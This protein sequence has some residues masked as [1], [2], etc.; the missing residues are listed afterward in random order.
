MFNKT[1]RGCIVISRKPHL[2]TCISIIQNKSVNTIFTHSTQK[3]HFKYCA[4]ITRTY[5]VLNKSMEVNRQYRENDE[6]K[7]QEFL[8]DPEN[9]LIFQKLELEVESYR[10]SNGRVP[11][12]LRPT[13][14]L[15]LL[16]ITSKSQRRGFLEFRWRIEQVKEDAKKMKQITADIEK[17]H[18]PIDQSGDIIRYGLHFNTMFMRI[19]SKMMNNFYNMRLMNAILYEPRIVYDLSY[20]SYMSVYESYNCAKQLV[21]AFAQNRIHKSPFN[22][23]FCNTNKSSLVMKQ[24]HKNIPTIYDDNFPL[25]VTEKSYLDIFDKDK[26]VYLTPDTNQ[27]L[28]KFDA[29]MVYIIGGMVDKMHPKRVSFAKAR[30]ER[31]QMARLPLSE[32]LPWGTGSTKNLPLNQVLAI[33]LDLHHT[34]DWDIA[35]KHIP[36]RKLKPARLLEMRK[37]MAKRQEM[38]DLLTS[39][40]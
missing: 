6:K 40:E 12:E 29:D 11:T 19:A 38:I 4:L 22:L 30:S 10:Y 8:A 18:V 2:N 34:N 36:R 23:Y 13:E 28:K 33:L 37:E 14:W 16:A 20:D 17:P 27:V 1:F 24:M 15:L 39:L 25:N 26:L 7:F 21:L 32:H 31:I 5:C 9:R 3:H 35:L